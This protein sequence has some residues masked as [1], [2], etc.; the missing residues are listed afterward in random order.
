MQEEY[1]DFPQVVNS[2]GQSYNR[3]RYAALTKGLAPPIRIGRSKLF[4]PDQVEV[5]RQYFA[6]QPRRVNGE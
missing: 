3:V 4:T 1:F 5:L 6:S 2:L